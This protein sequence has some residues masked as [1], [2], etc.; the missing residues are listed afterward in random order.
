MCCVLLFVGACWFVVR[1]SVL[2]VCC[3]LLHVG[4]CSCL[5]LGG[6]FRYSLYVGCCPLF[7]RCYLLFVAC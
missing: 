1:C 6:V 4:V 7:N 2:V 5:L 3:V